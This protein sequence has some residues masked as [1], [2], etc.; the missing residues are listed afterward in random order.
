MIKTLKSFSKTWSIFVF[1][2]LVIS[3]ANV[4]SQQ[5][6]HI[7]STFCKQYPLVNENKPDLPSPFLVDDGR[8]FVLALTKDKTYAIMDVTLSND[9]RICKQLVV[10]ST[11]F[12]TLAQTG[13]HSEK[14]LAGTKMITG[15][16]LAEITDIGRPGEFSEDGFMSPNEDILS[17][18][19]TDNEIVKRLGLTHA[20]MAK[21][22][23]QVINMMDIDIKLKRWNMAEH[24]WQNIPRFFYNGQTVHVEA[25]DTKGGQLSIFNDGIEGAFWFIIE[26]D[27]KPDEKRFLQKKYSFLTPAQF[28]SL[29]QKLTTIFTGEMEPQYIMRYGFYE[30]HAGWRADPVA[31]SFIFGLKTL[32]E[33]E[34]TFPGQ[35]YKLLTSDFTRDFA[36]GDAS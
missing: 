30:G 26:R 6:V 28:D 33:I 32:T 11:D 4:F 1:A 10:D 17:L 16:S 5:I 36:L 27:L 21:P 9:R 15:R 23:F 34:A 12:P 8:E 29:T 22:L 35:L 20:Q 18:L 24:E 19:Q 31:L 7:D 13:L 14:E 3:T 25:H 2:M